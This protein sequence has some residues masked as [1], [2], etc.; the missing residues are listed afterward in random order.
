[1][2]NKSCNV[3]ITDFKT[4]TQKRL[5]NQILILGVAFHKVSYLDHSFFIFLM[6]SCFLQPFS[7]HASAGFRMVKKII[8]LMTCL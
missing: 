8:L 6:H 5:V 2:P 7:M 4:I 3:I 1:M